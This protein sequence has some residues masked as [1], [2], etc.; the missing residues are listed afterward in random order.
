[1]ALIFSNAS[2]K[3]YESASSQGMLS[4]FIMG[5]KDASLQREYVVDKAFDKKEKA[6]R[7]K[8]RIK[9]NAPPEQLDEFL[10]S[11]V[12][13]RSKDYLTARDFS[14]PEL[15]SRQPVAAAGRIGMVAGAGLAAATAIR[16]SSGGSFTRNPSGQKD[17]AGIPFV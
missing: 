17:I 7:R 3:T 15:K 13:R 6:L 8:G 16:E 5:N 12:L 14:T 10:P 9:K 4:K 11:K 1:M 2:K